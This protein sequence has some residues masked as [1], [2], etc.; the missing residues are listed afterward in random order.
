M[1]RNPIY[2]DTV[3]TSTESTLNYRIESPQG[4]V[5]LKGVASER[6]DGT[7]IEIY[8][9]RLCEPFLS[10]S[11]KV[12]EGITTDPDAVRTFYLYNDLNNTLLETYAFIR[13][14][15]GEWNGSNKIL[16]DP[17]RPN[18]SHNMLLPF[19]IYLGTGSDIS[20]NG[21]SG[22]NEPSGYYLYFDKRNPA[23][24][25]EVEVPASFN[26][27]DNVSSAFKGK[28]VFIAYSNFI[29]LKTQF[30]TIPQAVLTNNNGLIRPLKDSDK[31]PSDAHRKF[32]DGVP[33]YYWCDGLMDGYTGGEPYICFYVTPNETFSPREAT[34]EFSYKG[35]LLCTLKIT[36]PTIAN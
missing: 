27:N 11:V 8:V 9:N 4:T 23:T 30:V 25:Y 16:N 20:I 33:Y 35:E 26:P 14:Y 7:P 28:E 34:F 1:T 17:I 12:E 29:N 36:Q 19:S 18:V 5:L 3:Y 13:A 6:P 10:Q 24:Y 22:G 31:V 32:I 2:K 21:G 15:S